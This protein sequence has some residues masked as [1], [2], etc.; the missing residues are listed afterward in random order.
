MKVLILATEDDANWGYSLS[1][2]F[3]M[4]DHEVTGLKLVRHAFDYPVQLTLSTIEE[5]QSAC[6]DADLVMFPQMDMEI[7]R[8]CYPYF[9]GKKVGVC[10]G[11]SYFRQNKK[12]CNRILNHIAAFQWVL[13]LDLID[14][15]TVNKIYTAISVDTD[16][17]QPDYTDYGIT[18]RHSPSSDHRKGTDE[19]LEILE[20][21]KEKY[22][23]ITIDVCTERVIWEQNLDRVRASDIYI[24][25]LMLKQGTELVG[26]WGM[27]SMEAAALGKIVVSNHLWD[28][29]YRK[30]YGVNPM[31]QAANSITEMY[32]TLE[33]LILMTPDQR[34]DLKVQTREWVEQYHSFE[35]TGERATKK[36]NSLLWKK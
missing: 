4:Q 18:I 23:E 6:L 8:Q 16:L 31:I 11:G 1:R 24:D 25:E 12:F 10:H 14:A 32:N 30:E 19:I 34:Y 13:E 9:E 27:S 36:I 5:M 21:L 17:I 28:N 22:P 33:K 2:I 29:E 15:G 7:F 26:S 20:Q 3:S 35:K